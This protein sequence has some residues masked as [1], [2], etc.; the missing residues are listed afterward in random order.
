MTS[1][2]FGTDATATSQQEFALKFDRMSLQSWGLSNRTLNALLSY[3]FKMTVGD[4]IRSGANLITIRG[5]G[6]AGIEELTKKVSQLLAETR[7]MK[8]PLSTD[9]ST[10]SSNPEE[11]VNPLPN[12][13]PQSAQSLPLDQLHLDIRTHNALVKAGITTIGELYNARDARISDIQRFHS[14]SLGNVNSSLIALM[15]SVNQEDKLN[16]LEYWRHQQIQ[17]LPTKN[18]PNAPSE[19]IIEELPT[20]IEEV[21]RRELDER[22]GIII[23]RRYGLGNVEKLTLEDIG[24]AFGGLSRE[25]IRQLE[26]RALKKLQ[27]IFIEQHYAGKNYHVHPAIH[28]MIQT[29]RDFIEAEPSKLILET[30]LLERVGQALN[31][32]I[33]KVKSSLLLILPL[34]GIERIEFDYLNS[35]PAWGYVELA[36]RSIL[37][38]GIKRLD[39]LLTRETPLPQTEFDILVNLNRKAKKSEKL[40]LAQLSWLIGLCNSVERREDGSIWGKFEYL[41]GRGN[42]VERL[43]SEFGVPMS[44]ADLAREINHRLV[45]L[46]KRR[47]VEQNL[48]NQIIGD[49]RF[50]AIGRSG[51][52]GLKL[53]KHID[54]KRV[55]TLMEESLIAS[56]KPATIDEIFTYVSQRRPVSKNSIILYL[57]TE[58]EH[59]VKVGLKTWG[60]AK[61]SDTTSSDSWNRERIADFVATI[62]KQN[63]VKELDYQVIKQALMDEFGIS[64]KQAQGLL[65]QNP[66]IKT[67]RG[68][69][70]GER[71]AV[72]QSNYKDV[73][74]QAKTKI[75]RPK[76]NLRQLLHETVR[77]ILEKA[78]DKQIPLSDLMKLL[79]KQFG[80]AE[81]TFYSYIN[82]MNFVERMDVP[83]SSKKICRLKETQISPISSRSGTLREKVNISVRTILEAVPNKQIPLDDLIKR[84]QKEYR[85][86]KAT[87]YQYIADLDYVER[88]DIPNSHA[89]LCRMKDIQRAE[90]FPQVQNITDTTLREKVER[91]LPF[92]TEENVDIGLF[93]LSKEFEA[94]LKTYLINASMK[95]KLSVLPQGKTPDKW[96]LNGMVECAKDNGIITDYATFHYLRQARNERAHG[97]MP[98]LAE[99]QL[100]MKSI[101]YIAGLYIDY[102]KLLDDLTQNL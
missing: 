14:G 42:Q 31:I 12:L 13:L 56:N 24:N 70:W 59:F 37:E 5:L 71:R 40:T 82:Q 75:P 21:L 33:R 95:G 94:T 47:I 28:I 76:V 1:L 80:I 9:R 4:A 57:T 63:K 61:W 50:V 60:L 17:V 91:A 46:G 27:G 45:P 69:K 32:D 26:E 51:K 90:L 22:S 99:R 43:L 73:L 52:W 7:N 29:I 66:V 15:N 3:N 93:L 68:T 16:W 35:V 18:M 49:D 19:Q 48:T 20:I 87:F 77:S 78:P 11:S 23:K 100:L 38:N 97:T 102:I 54:T 96:T 83:N 25:R 36:H 88:L 34:M 65:A 6:E 89:K 92:M 2:W 44:I 39:D 64:A 8:S 30:K 53:W 62:F 85:H 55:L 41:K 74:A 72:Y 84:L 101:Q 98:S 67:H 10:M 58:K 79:Q 81:S 86:P